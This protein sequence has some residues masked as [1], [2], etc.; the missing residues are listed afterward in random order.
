[1]STEVTMEKFDSPGEK[2]ADLFI[3]DQKFTVGLPIRGTT[4][5]LVWNS[6][7]T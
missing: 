4:V 5:R 3:R 2:F 7:T 1:M 6:R